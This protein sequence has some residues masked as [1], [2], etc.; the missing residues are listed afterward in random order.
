MKNKLMVYQG[1]G[2]DGC[3]W[4]WNAGYFDDEG[5]WRSLRAS[6]HAG[7][8]DHDLDK[9]LAMA[10]QLKAGTE[11][12]DLIPLS[13]VKKLRA[14]NESYAP[15]L[16]VHVVE[17]LHGELTD[18]KAV[19]TCDDCGEI[20]P[21]DE[22]GSVRFVDFRSNGGCSYNP[23]KK[24]CDDCFNGKVCQDCCER[25]PSDELYD[26][27]P[28]YDGRCFAHAVRNLAEQPSPPDTSDL[29]DELVATVADWREFGRL[30]DLKV[31]WQDLKK[32]EDEA[33]NRL[34][35]HFQQEYK[36]ELEGFLEQLRRQPATAAE[37]EKQGQLALK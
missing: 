3:F 32:I 34:D 33:F 1:G 11:K 29:P 35:W 16:V 17:A 5:Q 30:A 20:I 12:G 18:C 23:T 6:G 22:L 28:L 36:G 15:Q 27:E 19:V 37:S 24:L 26:S 2:Y 21:A 31:P 25:M 8:K 4:E 9:A 14:F 13:A 7:I 10:K